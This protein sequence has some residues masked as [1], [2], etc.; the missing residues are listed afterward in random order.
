MYIYTYMVVR[1]N[2]MGGSR[3]SPMGGT[4]PL[5]MHRSAS[6]HDKTSL[7]VPGDTLGKTK[8]THTQ[9]YIYTYICI[10]MYIER[11]ADNRCIDRWLN[12]F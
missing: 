6:I 9:I 12:P 4:A 11:Q 1:L 2:G 8:N 3:L 5:N 7:R 10:C